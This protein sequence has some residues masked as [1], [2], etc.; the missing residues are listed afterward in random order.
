MIVT[1][2]SEDLISPSKI[3]VSHNPSSKYGTDIGKEGLTN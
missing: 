3:N 1:L 2:F